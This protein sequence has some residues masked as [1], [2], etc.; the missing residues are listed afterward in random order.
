MMI[1]VLLLFFAS[2]LPAD[3]LTVAQIKTAM[4]QSL[5]QDD[6]EIE[7]VDYSRYPAPSGTLVFDRAAL[8]PAIDANAGRIVFWRGRID[9]G[10]TRTTSVWARVRL[11]VTRP[12]LVAR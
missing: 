12:Q 1:L 6:V 9:H 2:L 8:L 10:D 7:V 5:Q 3:E 11:V 4:F